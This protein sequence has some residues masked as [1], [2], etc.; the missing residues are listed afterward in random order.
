MKAIH[1]KRK[2][3]VALVMAGLVLIGLSM[4]LADGE[5]KETELFSG[6]D[7]RSIELRCKS[8][9][10]TLS[11]AEDDCLRVISTG[12][13]SYSAMAEDGLLTVEGEGRP[14][15]LFGNDSLALYLPSGLYERIEAQLS[16]GDIAA[17][18]IQTGSL[19][20]KT[21]S[22]SIALTDVTA[23]ES[24]LE[25]TSGSLRVFASNP[26]NCMGTVTS[27][28]ISFDGCRFAA[29]EL[30]TTSGGIRLADVRAEGVLKLTTGSGSISLEN[31]DAETLEIETGSGDVRG[32]LCTEKIFVA[33][34]SSGRIDVPEGVSGGICRVRTGSGD[35]SLKLLN[36]NG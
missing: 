9:D 20:A 21:T 4:V 8:A 15:D 30:K 24:R 34:S 7:I 32:T 31:G 6:K 11:P 14:F 33:R 25:T 28:D 1:G 18:G 16:S 10:I 19:S 3:M 23:D 12:N 22:G 13:A 5:R 27:G 35:I 2:L 29:A 17:R 26:G 36:E